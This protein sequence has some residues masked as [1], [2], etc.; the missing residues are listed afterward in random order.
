MQMSRTSNLFFQILLFCSFVMFLFI[1]IFS[2]ENTIS[3]YQ[4]KL[5]FLSYVFLFFILIIF[6]AVIVNHKLLSTKHFL[7]LIIGTGL[8]LRIFWVFYSKTPPVSDFLLMYEAAKKAAMGDFSFA[9]SGY[10]LRWGYQLGFTLYQAL[11]IKIFGEHLIV[12]KL[13]N[14]LFSMGTAVLMYHLAKKIFNEWCGKVAV[15]LYT[16]YIP[17]ILYC[18]VLTNQHISTFLFFLALYILINKGLDRKYHWIIIGILLSLGNLMRPLGSFFLLG[19]FVYICIFNIW[20]IRNKHSFEFAKKFVGILVVYLVV[21]KI[22]SM[23]LIHAGI[24]ETPLA[25]NDPYWKFVV[26]LNY[27]SKGRWNLADDKYVGQFEMGQERNA[28]ELSL[29]QERLSNKSKLL[30]LFMDKFKIF[31]GVADASQYWAFIDLNEPELRQLSTKYERIMYIVLT[32]FITLILFHIKKYNPFLS[33]FLILIL[34]YACVHLIVE[35][36]PRYRFDI[37]PIFFLLG[38]FGVYRS[39]LFIQSLI[40]KSIFFLKKEIPK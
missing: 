40:K 19:I 10:F 20:P 32:L 16:F 28:A 23:G 31:W 30:E 35:I 29:I 5:V 21:Q 36:Q 33:L 15:L 38:S 9:S 14:V 6:L 2:V 18:S 3:N 7:I 26:G 25:N 34:G 27:D 1:T 39:K 24:T 17:N 22:A 8:I 37:L 4:S 13:F 12:L 11:I